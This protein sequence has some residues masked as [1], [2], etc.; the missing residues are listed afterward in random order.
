MISGID[1]VMGRVLKQVDELGFG[2]N[3]VVIFIGDN[4]RC[5]LRGKC[6][7]YDGGIHVP[8]II[9]WP[10]H[11]DPGTVNSRPV[12]ALDLF[13]TICTAAEAQLP[14]GLSLDGVDLDAYRDVVEQLCYI[15]TCRTHWLRDLGG[16][17]SPFNAFLLLQGL[18][19]LS[20]RVQRH[21]DN[22][23][24]VVPDLGQRIHR[25]P[26]VAGRLPGALGVGG[27]GPLAGL[28]EER[29]AG[30]AQPLKRRRP[31]RVE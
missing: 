18:E 19:T 28:V 8:L 15:I 4:G 25:E 27:L 24:E 20:L 26:A 14:E 10:E 13:P 9:R 29:V 31:H 30:R 6:W 1:H 3:T 23:L 16:C 12:S 22:A 7:L 11:I 17:M 5:H 21:A 2:D